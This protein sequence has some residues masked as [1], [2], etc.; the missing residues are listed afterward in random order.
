[1]TIM[2]VTFVLYYLIHLD[3]QLDFL[4][5]LTP[6]KYYDAAVLMKDGLDPV[7]VGLSVLIVVLL[8]CCG[9]DASVWPSGVWFGAVRG[10]VPP[11]CGPR[12]PADPRSGG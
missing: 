9:A 10:S 11:L 3:N 2:L 8:R 5:Y 4:R 12:N 7:F 1:M 6:F